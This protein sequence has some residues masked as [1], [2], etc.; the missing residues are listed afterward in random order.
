MESKE[1][2]LAYALRFIESNKEIFTISNVFEIAE[3]IHQYL[4]PAKVAKKRGRPSKKAPWGY[5]KDGTPKQKP[6]R[7]A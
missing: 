5:K 2:A 3:K 7:K 6:G 4:T 1:K